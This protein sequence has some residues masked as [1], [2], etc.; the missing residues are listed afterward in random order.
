MSER[1]P[2]ASSAR[3]PLVGA[4][5]SLPRTPEPP[6]DVEER[7]LART[8][9]GSAFELASAELG[10]AAASWLFVENVAKVGGDAAVR[11]LGDELGTTFSVLDL[12][13]R[14]WLEGRRRPHVDAGRLRSALHG[15]RR[16]LVVGVEAEHLDALARALDPTVR[17]GLLT[18]RLQRVDWPRVLA[19]FGDRIE[20]VDLAEF[21][22]WA[23][24]RSGLLTFVYGERHGLVNVLSAFLRVSGPDVRTQFREII[25]WDVLGAAP[26]VYPR[27]LVE[28][29]VSDL[30]AFVPLAER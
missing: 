1:S 22:G 6:P 10:F 24:A 29:A 19:N 18:Y 28:T 21:Q 13:V 15:V 16:V 12:V 25:G 23:G 20:P 9:L 26:D 30:T 8:D 3:I 7:A 5:L 2:A 17:L 11:A 14:R 27:Y 4:P